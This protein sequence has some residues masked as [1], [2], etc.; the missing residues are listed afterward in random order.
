MVIQINPFLPHFWR[1]VSQLQI[2]LGAQ[3]VKLEDIT[4]TQE[5]LLATLTL[6]IAD[7]QLEAIARQLKMPLAD[8]T[9]LLDKVTPLLLKREVT[10]SNQSLFADAELVRATIA[11]QSDGVEVRRQRAQKTIWINELS[12][13]AVQLIVLLSKMGFQSFASSDAGL[14]NDADLGDYLR[15]TKGVTR[16]Q[17]LNY[18]LRELHLGASVHAAERNQADYAILLAQQCITPANYAS[19][20]N[21]G[22]P[23]QLATFAPDG[24]WVSHLVL[25]GRTPCLYCLELK[26]VDQDADW[27]VIASQLT[28]SK[29]RFDDCL[30][31]SFAATAIGQSISAWF[32]REQASTVAKNMD[33]ITGAI[34]DEPV[35]F[36]PDCQCSARLRFEQAQEPRSLAS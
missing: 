8:A 30:S 34:T 25:P 16:R 27:P 3:Q 14:V 15:V 6:G 26:R 33:A 5:R 1:N 32:D 2:G 22:I 36:H 29:T 19:L 7:H 28:T 9:D 13:T 31:A 11:N 18:Q 20:V 4:A 10:H 12:S 24:I 17:A 35:A 21:R 23:H